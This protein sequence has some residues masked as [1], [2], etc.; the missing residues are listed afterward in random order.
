V[1]EAP[2]FLLALALKY[3]RSAQTNK[4]DTPSLLHTADSNIEV[5]YRPENKVDLKLVRQRE[6]N[7]SS[8]R[9]SAVF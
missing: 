7:T 9:I 4:H 2:A 8:S 6:I 1:R 5:G 3:I